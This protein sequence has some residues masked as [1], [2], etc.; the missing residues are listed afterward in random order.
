MNVELPKTIF[1]DIDVADRCTADNACH[2]L[3]PCKTAG[4]DREKLERV[5]AGLR[6]ADHI[7]VIPV[8]GN[9]ILVELGGAPLLLE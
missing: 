8:L 7:P 3:Q 1:L 4:R 9:P 2:D 6:V 5:R